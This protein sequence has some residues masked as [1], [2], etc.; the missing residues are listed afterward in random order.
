MTNTIPTIAEIEGNTILSLLKNAYNTL[1]NAIFGKQNKLIAGDN[2]VINGDTISAIEGGTP[3]LDDYYTKEEVNE[4]AS[5]LSADIN[6]KADTDDVYDKTETYNKT[7]VYSKTE[8]DAL[9]G[10]LSGDVEVITPTLT[11]LTKGIGF[12]TTLKDGDIVV[13]DA[14]NGSNVF[15]MNGIVGYG[16]LNKARSRFSNTSFNFTS[17]TNFSINVMSMYLTTGTDA[18]TG[19]VGNMINKEYALI[20]V[21]NGVSLAA[22]PSTDFISATYSKVTIYRKKEVTE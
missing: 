10:S 2:I 8:V 12:T 15:Q 4:I 7:E 22:E 14:Y 11:Q 13:V 5:E 20:N 1:R 21:N 19:F 9:V 16:D 17:T 3:V 6:D 18:E